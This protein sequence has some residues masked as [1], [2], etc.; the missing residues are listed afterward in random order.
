MFCSH[1]HKDLKEFGSVIEKM[2][3]CPWCGGVLE[4]K[5]PKAR[6]KGVAALCETLV[7]KIGEKVF[8]KDS[9]LDDELKKISAPEFEDAKDR[10]SLLVM[11]KIPS[12]MYS[13]KEY[14]EGEQREVLDACSKRLCFDL[15]MQFEPSAEM[16]NLLQELVWKKKYALSVNYADGDFKDPRDGHVYKTVKIGNQVWMKENLKYKCLGAAGE[17]FYSKQALQYAAVQGWRFPTKNDF[18]VLVNYAK[19]SGYGDPSSVLMSLSGWEKFAV[20]P[21]DNLG[22]DAKPFKDSDYVHYWLRDGSVFEITLGKVFVGHATKSYI[23]L[24]KDDRI[25]GV[26]DKKTKKV[27]AK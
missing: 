9:L 8:S 20:T 19:Q 5:Q 18:D 13:V 22:F 6:Q 14:S 10:M 3:N 2:Q 25:E 7:K 1:C 11:K 27:A 4:K 24:I 15:G 16:L 12:S 26:S 21:T 17:D 23:R